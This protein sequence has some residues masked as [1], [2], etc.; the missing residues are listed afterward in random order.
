[1]HPAPLANVGAGQLNIQALKL[2]IKPN[3]KCGPQESTPGHWIHIDCNQYTP[4]KLARAFSPRKLQLFTKGGLRLDSPGGQL[5]DGVD[6][7]NDGT[8][9]PIK[10]QGQVGSCTSFSLS[11]AMDNAIRRMNKPDTTSSLHLWSHYGYPDMQTA[12]DSNVNKPIVTWESWPYDE[13]VACELD[14]SGEGDCGPYAPP[15]IPGSGAV[16]AQV[17]AKIKDADSK[18]HWKVTGYDTIPGDPDT[19]ASIL[20]TGADVWFSMNIGSTWMSPQGDTIADWTWDQVEGGHA[21][22]FAGYRHKNG[23]RQFLVHNSWGKDWGDG[24]YAWI[25]DNAVKQF[26]KHAYK[27][28]ISDT[29]APPPPPSDPNALTDD[30]CAENEL[31]DSVSGQC[32]AMCPDDSRPASGQCG[33]AA[34]AK[35]PPAKQEPK[36]EPKHEEPKRH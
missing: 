17:Q 13:R 25:S 27:V 9:G 8:E 34:A 3:R 21:I 7:R 33:G 35:R 28:V 11:S 18:G 14:R 1:V 24:G 19:I 31:V 22:L 12:G 20:A 36:V 29:S 15:A 5:P 10:D 23:Q 30:D 16:D 32:S 4:V 2:K 26:I 6:H